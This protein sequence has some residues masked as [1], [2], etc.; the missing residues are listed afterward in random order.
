M[1]E[2]HNDINLL[3]G[4]IPINKRLPEPSPSGMVL[5]WGLDG[6]SIAY[7]DRP[8]ER[9]AD[10]WFE[11]GVTH[12]QPL[13]LPPTV[14]AEPESPSPPPP[15]HSPAAEAICLVGVDMS[16]VWMAGEGDCAR[17]A[18]GW[19]RSDSGDWVP[20][21]ERHATH[22]C[23]ALP[24]GVEHVSP[25]Y[26]PPD[27]DPDRPGPT[28]N[29]PLAVA[30]E[31]AI[32]AV[33]TRCLMPSS[34][35]ELI[36]RLN[37]SRPG[38]RDRIRAQARRLHQIGRP[39]DE[40]LPPWEP[41]AEADPLSSEALAELAE[42]LA[43]PGTPSTEGHRRALVQARRMLDEIHRLRLIEDVLGRAHD[44]Q[45]HRVAEAAED[46]AEEIHRARQAPAPA[47][48]HR[49]DNPIDETNAQ[50]SRIATVLERAAGVQ[51]ALAAD[52]GLSP[53]PDEEPCP[54]CGCRVKL[55]LGCGCPG[56]GLTWDEREGI[57]AGARPETP[58]KEPEPAASDWVTGWSTTV[59]SGGT[60]AIEIAGLLADGKGWRCV[61]GRRPQ[62][63]FVA[64]PP[65]EPDATEQQLA[66][67]LIAALPRCEDCGEPATRIGSDG[68]E[69]DVVCLCDSCRPEQR[70]WEVETPQKETIDGLAE[71]V[72]RWAPALRALGS[73]EQQLT[74]RRSLIVLVADLAAAVDQLVRQCD[75]DESEDL[76]WLNEAQP[77]WRS[78]LGEDEKR[79]D[80]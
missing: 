73:G 52:S 61:C 6:Y 4:W 43:D 63:R 74:A 67:D 62:L 40:P 38:W 45:L 25:S 30:V 15:K 8:E 47:I 71:P 20:A 64:E 58:A 11:A 72:V 70:L 7:W 3:R 68:D 29:Y 33:D 2:K 18:A 22:L 78:F 36:G 46:I 26:R 80:A 24:P 17:R 49:V 23:G 21:C 42:A 28:A 27:T 16:T 56:C 31:L 44:R 60:I 69:R 10:R 5:G 1:S 77:D 35:S 37:C 34:V 48:G 13:P 66:A 9:T 79:S 76:G 54:A 53:Y 12:W 19:A 55:K 39:P 50:L 41:T 65:A 51:E 32:A 59:E 14:A 57:L 75:I